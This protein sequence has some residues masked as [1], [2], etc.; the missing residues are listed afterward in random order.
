ML[1]RDTVRRLIEEVRDL[2]RQNEELRALLVELEPH[3][4]AARRQ[5]EA[6]LAAL[7]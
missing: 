4:G 7:S 3:F 5:L 6:M 2:H 1:P